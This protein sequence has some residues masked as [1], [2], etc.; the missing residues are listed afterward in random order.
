MRPTGTLD[1]VDD[2][3]DFV[4]E[5]NS[6]SDLFI[7]AETCL[8]KL[9]ARIGIQ[10]DSAFAKWHFSSNL[11]D[12]DACIAHEGESQLNYLQEMRQQWRPANQDKFQL[13][14]AWKLD[15][16]LPIRQTLYESSDKE[17]EE[18]FYCE[19]KV[20]L[21]MFLGVVAY[22]GSEHDEECIIPDM[23]VSIPGCW[24]RSNP[25]YDFPAALAGTGH[26]PSVDFAL[27]LHTV[28]P[29]RR[30]CARRDK[31]LRMSILHPALVLG[32][33]GPTPWPGAADGKA[34]ASLSDILRDLASA[35]QPSL[36]THLI[37]WFLHCEQSQEVET[38]LSTNHSALPPWMILFGVVYD[39]ECIRIIAHIPFV[40]P[41]GEEA[42]QFSYLSCVVDSIS[43]PPIPSV[44]QNVK[45]WTLER[46]RSA[47]A[48]LT[49][50]THAF[51]FGSRWEDVRWPNSVTFSCIV[52]ESEYLGPTP[53]PSNHGDL[54]VYEHC[55]ILDS[56]SDTE[57]STPSEHVRAYKEDEEMRMKA[58]RPKVLQWLK[59][60]WGTFG[61]DEGDDDDTAQSLLVV[62]HGPSS[63]RVTC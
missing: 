55:V 2:I 4:S 48:L 50:Q 62:G 20:S 9:I 34:N 6:E 41:N 19:P 25:S 38:L 16:L 7:H 49:I 8:T 43:Y 10:P 31:C 29:S 59:D 26:L 63:A 60:N 11:A 54:E 27:L 47:I 3:A 46:F 37:S 35:A 33:K 1:S 42:R 14:E 15:F 36:D 22:I 51:R 21:E 57:C 13:P 24:L 52:R 45:D 28:G 53:T 44:I 18:S 39:A 32:M 40:A 58:S 30:F 23:F 56:D 17:P 61:D 5:F 12:L